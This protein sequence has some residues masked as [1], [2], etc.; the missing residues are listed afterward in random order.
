MTTVIN[1]AMVRKFF[2]GEDPL[3]RQIEMDMT[4][5]AVRMTVVGVVGDV[6]IDGMNRQVLPELYLPMAHQPS[7]NAWVVAH[8]RSNASSALESLRR[9]VQQVDPEIGIVEGT[10]M[11][12]EVGDSLWRERFSALLV[13]LFA[14]LAVLIASGGLYAVISHAVERRTQELGVRV[15]LGATAIHIA[16]TVLGHGLRVWATGMAAGA[17]L[18][19]AVS[20]LLPQQGYETGDLPWMFAAV[21]SL[22]LML[23][24]LA[25]WIPLRR[26]LAV[27]PMLTL[28]SE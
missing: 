16:R 22:L 15:A 4:S 9:A 14:A 17:A 7:A 23:T 26:A 24:L 1:Q 5:F 28:R 19:M 20:H 11:T 3:G 13:G 18:T 12:G 21:A 25:C 27:D 8:A 6:R 10:T 2:A